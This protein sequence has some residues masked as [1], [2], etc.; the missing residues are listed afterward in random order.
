MSRACVRSSSSALSKLISDKTT[1]AP[2]AVV[3]AGLAQQ[4]QQ[5]RFKTK[6][7]AG[8]CD[9]TKDSAGRRLGVKLYQG[10]HAKAGSIIVRQ[11]GAKFRPGL[12]AG[13]GRDHT[14]FAKAHGSVF[15]VTAQDNKKRSYVNIVEIPA[16][17]KWE[18]KFGLVT[19]ADAD[20]SEMQSSGASP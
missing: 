6:K 4:L 20:S 14:I 5:V 10:Q 15:F 18:P 9:Q 11:R 12:N 17:N 2:A 1:T 19:A 16:K 7:A 3:G 8:S 13:M